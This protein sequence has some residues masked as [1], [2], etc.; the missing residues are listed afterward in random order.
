MA[1][2]TSNG[3]LVCIWEICLQHGSLQTDHLQV[4]DISKSLKDLLDY[5]GFVYMNGLCT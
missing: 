5:E 2:I 1:S 3:S 4:T